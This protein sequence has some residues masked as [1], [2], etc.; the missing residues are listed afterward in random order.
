MGK[1][2]EHPESEKLYCEE[3]DLGEASGM[4]TIAS[5][6]RHHLK[7]EDLQDRLVVVLANLKPR[8][9][10]GFVSQGMVLCATAADGKVRLLEPPTGAQVG[11][12]VTI[13]GVEMA[14][15]D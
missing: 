12:R 15:A 2:W 14:D 9:M 6:L 4:R 5:G 1:V 13:D 7:L 3:I 8:K 11:E 10:L